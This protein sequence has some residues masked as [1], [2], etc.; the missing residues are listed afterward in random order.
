MIKH[1]TTIY[2]Y[3]SFLAIHICIAL[4]MIQAWLCD[5]LGFE[6]LFANA[7]TF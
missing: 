2:S 4:M 3:L 6:K 5:A 1:L 7:N